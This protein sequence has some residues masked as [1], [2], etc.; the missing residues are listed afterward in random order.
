MLM[1]TQTHT[2]TPTRTHIDTYIVIHT[3]HPHT[4]THIYMLF[5]VPTRIFI[6]YLHTQLH[7]VSLGSLSLL[8]TLTKASLPLTHTCCALLSIIATK[9]AISCILI[10]SQSLFWAAYFHKIHLLSVLPPTTPCFVSP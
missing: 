5:F 8:V 2:R 10:L 4:F 9:D 1:H 7:T 6:Y 3:E